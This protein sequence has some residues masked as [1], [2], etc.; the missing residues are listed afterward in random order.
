VIHALPISSF[1]RYRKYFSK[2]EERGILL[3]IKI[4]NFAKRTLLI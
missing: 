3:G 2:K 4:K 1:Y